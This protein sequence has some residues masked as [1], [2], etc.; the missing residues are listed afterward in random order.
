MN[1][2]GIFGDSFAEHYSLALTAIDKDRPLND[3]DRKAIRKEFPTWYS[4]LPYDV[5]SY[6]KGGADI[7]Y[8]LKTFLQHQHK[9]DKIIIVPTAIGRYSL[10][11][12][13]KTFHCSND[14]TANSFANEF[15]AN[16]MMNKMFI[17]IRNMRKHVFPFVDNRDVL[18]YELCIAH[19]IKVRPDVKI[20][21]AFSPP[22]TNNHILTA[23]PCPGLE[24]IM[25][26]EDRKLYPG[27]PDLQ[28][29]AKWDAR[30]SHLTT[31]TH[32][33]LKDLITKLLNTNDTY[34][35]IDMIDF[36]NI[37]PDSKRYRVDMH[38]TIDDWIAYNNIGIDNDR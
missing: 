7:H 36:N 6:A 29:V 8:C 4:T 30:M 16:P 34:L 1:K 28:S 10:M 5:T 11:F 2:I 35:R 33:I 38:D 3:E 12:N 17:A 27:I 31:E 22:I 21:F 25:K 26:H 15:E 18:F 19:M 9:Y 13:E 32:L 37:I 14:D 20:I 23:N 24:V